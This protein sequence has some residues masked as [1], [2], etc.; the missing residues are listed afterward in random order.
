GGAG[1][2]PGTGVRAVDR[3]PHRRRGDDG[4]HRRGVRRGAPGGR[5]WGGRGPLRDV[6]VRASHSGPRATGGSPPRAP[7]GRIRTTSRRLDSDAE[8]TGYAG[9]WTG[10]TSSFSGIRRWWTASGECPLSHVGRPLGG[11]SGRCPGP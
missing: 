2:G 5:T 3:A 11:S 9:P 4:G 8:M 7:S 6:R 1:D 10:F